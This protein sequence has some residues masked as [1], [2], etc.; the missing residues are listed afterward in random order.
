MPERLPG[1][2]DWWP[3]TQKPLNVELVPDAGE[4]VAALSEIA[5]YLTVLCSRRC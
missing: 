4:Q 5:R 2:V 1:A 3:S